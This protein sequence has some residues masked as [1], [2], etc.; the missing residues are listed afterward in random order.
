M[1]TDLSSLPPVPPDAPPPLDALLARQA[2]VV[3]R[4]QALAAGLSP[5]AVDHR[6]RTRR[7]RPLHPRVYLATHHRHGAEARVR[8]ALLWAGEGAVL[9]GTAAA[10]WHGL[11]REAPADVGV[12]VPRGR[13][14]RPRPGVLVRRR[15]VPAADVVVERGLPV[16]GLPLTVLDAAVDMGAA[17]SPFLRAVLGGAV[18][19]AGA[20]GGLLAEVRAAHRR[21]LGAHGSA[22]AA[23]LLAG[24]AP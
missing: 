21:S 17:G 12:S 2:G 18:G 19:A 1:S 13:R 5:G 10:W 11:V 24:V 7:W 22:T 15:A 16:T 23:R 3:T 8:A 9:C 20:P 6:L 14:P 4:A